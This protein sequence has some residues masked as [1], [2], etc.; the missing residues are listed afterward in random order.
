MPALAAVDDAAAALVLVGRVVAAV[1]LVVVHAAEGQVVPLEAARVRQPEVEGHVAL[2]DVHVQVR[3]VARRVLHHEGVVVVQGGPAPVLAGVSH[4]ADVAR[5]VARVAEEPGPDG[6]QDVA[7]E[8]AE[9]L[10]HP[11]VVQDEPVLVHAV[12]VPQRQPGSPVIVDLLHERLAELVRQSGEAHDARGFRAAQRVD[13]GEAGSRVS[14]P[15]VADREEFRSDPP[16]PRAGR[17][18]RRLQRLPRVAE[19]ALVLLQIAPHAEPL[20]WRE[21]RPCLFD[22]GIRP[23]RRLVGLGHHGRVVIRVVE[24]VPLRIVQDHRSQRGFPKEAIVDRRGLLLARVSSGRDFD[25]HD[26]P[27]Y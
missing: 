20:R 2:V 6:Q 14:P 12:R 9:G 10:P 3:V 23:R 21:R 19:R 5:A 18:E 13:S 15:R 25:E 11:D 26:G 24:V 27:R 22:L 17:K 7:Q 16:A 4:A 8:G 1:A